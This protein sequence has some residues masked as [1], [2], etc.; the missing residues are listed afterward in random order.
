[1]TGA[2][3]L[4][5]LVEASIVLSLAAAVV[6]LARRAAYGRVGAVWIY[7][8]WLAMPA[9]LLATAAP[10]GIVESPLSLT[11]RAGAAGGFGPDGAGPSASV[12]PVGLL[13]GLALAVWLAGAAALLFHAWR[14]QRRFA[15]AVIASARW[16]TEAEVRA[17]ARAAAGTALDPIRDVRFTALLHGP[18]V[19]GLSRPVVL[20]PENFLARYAADERRVMLL[21]EA[22]HI[23]AQHL[24]HRAAAAVLRCLFWFH[25]LAWL[26]E[27]AFLADQEMACD[28]AVLNRDLA[29]RPKLYAATLLKAVGDIAD[30]SP[31]APAAS[32]AL[33]AINQLKGRTAMLTRHT[34][35]KGTRT[36]G[37]CLLG[38]VAAAAV[39]A[40]LSAVAPARSQDFGA[41]PQTRDFQPV[42]R[43]PPAYPQEAVEAKLDGRCV[44]E[45]DIDADGAPQNIHAVQCSDGVF[46]APSLESVRQ[47]RFDPATAG[48]TT[49]E[50]VVIEF[51]LED[52]RESE[53]G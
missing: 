10:N 40:G 16:P 47:W 27:R 45:Y 12:A 51:Q 33:I 19:C 46:A 7:A 44:M 29:I 41:E 14:A 53:N 25:P 17:L 20:L 15:R 30:A 21:H 4:A 18:M 22:E 9:G 52:D 28:Q 2:D 31:P 32:T 1:M 39:L 26:A 36:V 42:Y 43:I 38:A 37:L 11:V 23:A 5:W 50:R 48:G 24:Q 8:L 34:A 35:P 3:L 6:L 13:V 49:G